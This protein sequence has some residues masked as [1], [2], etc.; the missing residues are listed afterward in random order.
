MIITQGVPG[1]GLTQ[2]QNT[3]LLKNARHWMVLPGHFPPLPD[4]N[5]QIPITSTGFGSLAS[6]L[7]TAD[8]EANCFLFDKID[9]PF[10]FYVNQTKRGPSVEREFRISSAKSMNDV[11][12]PILSDRRND[13]DEP[14]V[15]CLEVMGIFCGF[16]ISDGRPVMY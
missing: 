11:L 15:N 13:G 12:C 6:S 4:T 16:P 8:E 5:G 3:L 9:H 1:R 7:L 2:T 14:E 10:I